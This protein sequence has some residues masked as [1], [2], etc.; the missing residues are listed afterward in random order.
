[1]KLW[2]ENRVEGEWEISPEEVAKGFWKSP[3]GESAQKGVNLE[4]CLLGYI[5]SD[6][7]LHST[8]LVSEQQE[9]WDRVLTLTLHGWPEGA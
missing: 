2:R 4:R 3:D 7:G 1:V 9:E 8:F 5:G 6:E